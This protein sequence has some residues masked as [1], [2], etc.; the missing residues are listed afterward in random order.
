M[1]VA[2]ST[3]SRTAGSHS[4]VTPRVPPGLLTMDWE[5]RERRS[6]NA[7]RDQPR[8]RRAH[9]VIREHQA[10][11]KGGHTVAVALHQEATAPP[12][13]VRKDKRTMMRTRRWFTPQ[14]S[15]ARLG[16]LREAGRMSLRERTCMWP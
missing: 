14:R 1:S 6:Y 7:E 8:P 4:A 2:T 15:R 12:S 11:A 10:Q 5:P 16:V 3:A 9:R 13:G